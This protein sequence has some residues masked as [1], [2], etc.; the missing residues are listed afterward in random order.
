MDPAFVLHDA[1]QK[2]QYSGIRN[3]KLVSTE[4]TSI[5]F[6]RKLVANHNCKKYIHILKVTKDFVKYFDLITLIIR[7]LHF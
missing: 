3:M 4:Y 1:A 2:L 6:I 7:F 5:M